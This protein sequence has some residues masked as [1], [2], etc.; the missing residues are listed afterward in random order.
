MTPATNII[1]FFGNW[2]NEIDKI[3]KAQIRV[4]VCAIHTAIWNCRND[5]VFNNANHAQVFQVILKAT[6]WIGIWSFLLSEEQRV[7]TDSGYL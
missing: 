2:L 1:N 4:G 6:Y 5:V 7:R 3:T